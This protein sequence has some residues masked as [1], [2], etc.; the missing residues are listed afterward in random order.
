MENP[1]VKLLHTNWKFTFLLVCPIQ[2]GAAGVAAKLPRAMREPIP[3]PLC[4]LKM[5]PNMPHSIF[6]S[7][8]CLFMRIKDV[9]W[10]KYL[11]YLFE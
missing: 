9:R 10:V 7:S 11:L 4:F 5:L 3:V 1:P 8:I 2:E 6:P